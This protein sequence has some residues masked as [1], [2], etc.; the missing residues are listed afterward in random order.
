M[1]KSAKA[2]KTLSIFTR[3]PGACPKPEERIKIAEMLGSGAGFNHHQC[4][5]LCRGRN[6][7]G[8]FKIFLQCSL[9]NIKNNS[10]VYKG[11]KPAAANTANRP[12]A[13]RSA[14]NVNL[15]VI[16]LLSTAISTSNIPV[17]LTEQRNGNKRLDF[18]LP[19]TRIKGI[20]WGMGV[21]VVPATTTWIQT[22]I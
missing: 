13:V 20:I 14:K 12:A 18:S 7:S 22:F 9:F 2:N 21:G 11:R 8:S 10:R 1:K 3:A 19:P 15:K 4:R 16:A 17:S 6:V 5:G